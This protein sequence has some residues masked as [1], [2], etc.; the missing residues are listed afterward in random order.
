MKHERVVEFIGGTDEEVAWLRLSLRR[1][2]VRLVDKWRLRRDGDGQVDLMLIA[3]NGETGTPLPDA[4]RR[5][6]LR[7]ASAANRSC[8]VRHGTSSEQ[9]RPR[10]VQ[11]RT[12]CELNRPPNVQHRARCATDKQRR[13]PNRT[14]HVRCQPRGVHDQQHDVRDQQRDVRDLW[15]VGDAAPA[16]SSPCVQHLHGG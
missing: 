5:V 7:A 11:D 9:H 4:P 12:P 13:A 16:T 6:R 14:R 15:P 8:T 2:A 1:A 3:D 10:H